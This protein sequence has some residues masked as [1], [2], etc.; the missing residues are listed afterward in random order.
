MIESYCEEPSFRA[1]LKQFPEHLHPTAVVK[2]ASGTLRF[3]VLQGELGGTV[4]RACART[5]TGKLAS[6]G[7][8]SAEFSLSAE[9]LLSGGT[10]ADALDAA[11]S[12]SAEAGLSDNERAELSVVSGSAPTES[13]SIDGTS[14]D[15]VLSDSNRMSKFRILFHIL[16]LNVKT[17]A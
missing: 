1:F 9:G 15:F 16:P 7:P 14:V 12:G 10:S 13:I 6:A 11:E 8:D 4:R 3:G 5:G 2:N 17:S